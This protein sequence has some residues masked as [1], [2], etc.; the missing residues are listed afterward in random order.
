MLKL[1]TYHGHICFITL[2]FTQQYTRLFHFGRSSCC[3][4]T[5]GIATF[6]HLYILLPD[7]RS[8]YSCTDPTDE[9][10]YSR[11]HDTWRHNKCVCMIGN[12]D[13][14]LGA[15]CVCRRKSPV[16]C[17]GARLLLGREHLDVSGCV[18]LQPC[19]IPSSG[20]GFAC[21]LLLQVET[22]AGTPSVGCTLENT[23]NFSIRCPRKR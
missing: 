18:L 1:C 14:V 21:P 4:S 13:F 5:P 22:R 6:Y 12:H 7:A 20:R 2:S 15:S 23:Q 19:A 10:T 17:G 9:P 8:K 3:C 11:K 16:C